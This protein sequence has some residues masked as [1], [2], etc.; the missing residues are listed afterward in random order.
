MVFNQKRI[1]EIIE[2]TSAASMKSVE[3]MF[4]YTKDAGRPSS[5]VQPESGS[6][7]D[8]RAQ[9]AICSYATVILSVRI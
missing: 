1:V 8:L 2:R 7:A 3:W 5:V 9:R 6:G 4:K